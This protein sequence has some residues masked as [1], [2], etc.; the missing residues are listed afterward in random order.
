MMQDKSKWQIFIPGQVRS[1][2]IGKLL[3]LTNF[4]QIHY[5]LLKIWLYSRP[6]IL[7]MMVINIHKSLLLELQSSAQE[8]W[9]ISHLF[10]TLRK[11]LSILD[12]FVTRKWFLEKDKGILIFSRPLFSTW[13]R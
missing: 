3:S 8:F 11:K 12:L 6:I 4:N 10:I 2:V 5:L 7:T 9:I 1:Q 13:L